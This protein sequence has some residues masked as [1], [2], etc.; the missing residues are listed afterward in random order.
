MIK[1]V[2]F[3]IAASIAIALSALVLSKFA[4][5]TP[6][7]ADP[8]PDMTEIATTLD[9]L[10]GYA[11]SADW[12]RYFALYH[13]DAVFLGTDA[14]ERWD[15]PTFQAY[16]AGTKGWVYTPRE[17]HIDLT[18]DGRTAYFDE[19]L[20]SRNYG[21]SRGTGVLIRD[22]GAWRLLQYHL[23]FPIPNDL[24]KEITMMIQGFERK[25]TDTD[26]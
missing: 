11:A 4:D 16:A 23:T 18:P 5:F 25:A 6:V 7:H 26:G 14:G 9:Q 19:I 3:C 2:I 13:A 10:H 17:R 24:A 15:K 21:T 12:P 8:A 22:N 1:R 20:D